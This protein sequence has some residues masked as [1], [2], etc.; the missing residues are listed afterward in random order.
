MT[1]GVRWLDNQLNSTHDSSEF[2]TAVGS[3]VTKL[4]VKLI[5]MPLP[6]GLIKIAEYKFKLYKKETLQGLDEIYF[7]VVCWSI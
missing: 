7:S 6:I 5:I 3:F 4:S 2:E 1:V